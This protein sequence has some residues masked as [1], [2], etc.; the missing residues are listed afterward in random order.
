[1]ALFDQERIEHDFT[2]V[3]REVDRVVTTL[4]PHVVAYQNSWEIDE[5]L[6]PAEQHAFNNAIGASAAKPCGPHFAHFT[7]DQDYWARSDRANILWHQYDTSLDE[8]GLA[9]ETRQLVDGNQRVTVVTHE[10]SPGVRLGAYTHEQSRAR[11]MVCRAAG[12]FGG[13]NG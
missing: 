6:L 12:A 7:P 3:L 8:A 11:G 4:D 1:M 10:H 2:A 5:V 9:A 13:M